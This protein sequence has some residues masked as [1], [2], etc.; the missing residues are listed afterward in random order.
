MTDTRKTGPEGGQ[1][2]PLTMD[3]VGRIHETSLRVLEEIG[4]RVDLPEAREA[5]AA[6]GAQVDE[7][8]RVVTI[9]AHHVEKAL[10]I[11]RQEITLFARGDAEALPLENRRTYF[12]TGGAAIYVEDLP[13]GEA[14]KSSLQDIATFAILT[15]ELQNIDFFVTPCTAQDVA[16]E[17]LAVNEFYAALCNTAKHVIGPVYTAEGARQVIQLGELLA[18]PDGHTLVER[19]FFS[20]TISWM[21]SP[22]CFDSQ[23]TAALMEVVRAGLPVTLSAAPMAG[24]TSPITLAGTLVQLHAEELAGIVFTQAVRPGAPVI[25]G[26]IPGMADMRRLTYVGGGVEFGMMNAAIAQMAHYIGMP[27]HNSAGVTEAKIPDIQAVYEKCF[28]VL[29]CALSGSNLIH[30]A[31]GI[32]ES[33]LTISHAQLV[34]DNEIIGMAARAVE[35]ISVNIEKMAFDTIRE[36]AHGGTYL[37]TEHTVRHLAEEFIQPSLADR[38]DRHAWERLGM[39]AIGEKA[40]QRAIDL[41]QGRANEPRADLVPLALDRQVR[42]RFPIMERGGAHSPAT[43]GE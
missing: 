39:Q 37:D 11:A 43:S 29:Q 23:A 27:N 36:V 22:L 28:A 6:C 15:D 18:D 17:H 33:M 24:A 32:L 30:H 35:G 10:E 26:G 34:I 21:N 38:S 1:Y 14:R 13:T 3:R 5:F 8:S 4:V 41:L 9:R 31:A 20:T 42:E 2:C 16:A 12:G 25:Y 7:A 40:R 19:P